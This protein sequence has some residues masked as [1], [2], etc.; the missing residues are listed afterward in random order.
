MANFLNSI[1]KM[2]LLVK[3]TESIPYIVAGIDSVLNKKVS[4]GVTVIPSELSKY[5]IF[6]SPPIPP[7]LYFPLPHSHHLAFPNSHKS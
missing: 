6:I 1:Y 4:F 3:L 5:A 7:L 2:K